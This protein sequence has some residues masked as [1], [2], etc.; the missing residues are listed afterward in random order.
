MALHSPPGAGSAPSALTPPQE[1]WRVSAEQSKAEATQRA[2]EEQRRVVARQTAVEREELERAKVGPAAPRSAAGPATC[3]G[4]SPL[5]L[6]PLSQSALLEEQKVVMRKCGEEQRRLAAEWAEFFAQQKL[7][8]ERA[9][10]EAERALQADSKRE[11]TLVSLAKV[12]PGAAR[13]RGLLLR[14]R[15]CLAEGT[16]P[17]QGRQLPLTSIQPSPCPHDVDTLETRKL[18]FEE[19]EPRVRSSTEA[20]LVWSLDPVAPLPPPRLGWCGA[21]A[22]GGWAREPSN[23]EQDAVDSREENAAKALPSPGAGRAKDQGKRAPGQGGPAGRREGGPGAGAAG[24]AA[25]AGEGQRSRPAHP[26]PC[27]GGGEDEPGARRL[28]SRARS[29]LQRHPAPGPPR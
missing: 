25:G 2:L 11:G 22:V 10:R 18:G 20:W 7:S 23:P 8:K 16:A 5:A 12:G 6:T 4:R 3:P 21:V 26:A 13:P 9:E 14:W 1:R 19:F 17:M 27:R 15:V 28:S 29:G 24:A